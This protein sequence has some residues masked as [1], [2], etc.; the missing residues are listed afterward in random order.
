MEERTGHY[1]PD[2]EPFVGYGRGESMNF[3]PE[4]RPVYLSH[5]VHQEPIPPAVMGN[6]TAIG[7]LLV[8]KAR[9]YLA[10]SPLAENS[11]AF[12]GFMMKQIIYDMKAVASAMAPIGMDLVPAD[13]IIDILQNRLMHILLMLQ[14]P[15]TTSRPHCL[16]CEDP[17]VPAPRICDLSFKSIVCQINDG[18]CNAQVWILPPMREWDP[19]AYVTLPSLSTLARVTAS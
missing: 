17:L 1:R 11:L 14:R 10:H 16:C 5:D 15:T 6:L 4:T 13:I 7:W 19:P 18:V 9:E 2:L 8:W 3:G 12:E